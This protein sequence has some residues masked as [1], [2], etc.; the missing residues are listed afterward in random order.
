MEQARPRA[1]SESDYVTCQALNHRPTTR[2]SDPTRWQMTPP[3]KG[4]FFHA[5]LHTTPTCQPAFPSS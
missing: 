5:T 2:P 3:E 4:R 1:A